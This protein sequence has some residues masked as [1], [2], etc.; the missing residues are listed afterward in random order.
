MSLTGGPTDDWGLPQHS[1][2]PPLE[3][4]PP[5]PQTQ[6]DHHVLSA[7]GVVQHAP[8]QIPDLSNLP[9]QIILD[10]LAAKSKAELGQ[11]ATD[12]NRLG[13]KLGKRLVPLWKNEKVPQGCMRCHSIHA[14]CDGKRPCGRCLSR[15]VEAQCAY[16]S[17]PDFVP[18]QRKQRTKPNKRPLEESMPEPVGEIVLEVVAKAHSQQ[19]Q[20][21]HL[22]MPPQQP[23]PM[24]QQREQ[25]P[26]PPQDRRQA[27]RAAKESERPLRRDGVTPSGDIL[28]PHGIEKRYCLDPGCVE[29]GAGKAMCQHGRRK[30]SCKEPDCKNETERKRQE[31]SSRRCIHGRQKRLCREG[32]CLKEYSAASKAYREQMQQRRAEGI[33]PSIKLPP[34]VKYIR[35]VCQQCD[36]TAT[37]GLKADGRKVACRMHKEEEHVDL[38]KAIC[39]VEGCTRPARFGEVGARPT[40]CVEHR[41]P[42][43]VDCA[44]KRCEHVDPPTDATSGGIIC[45]AGANYGDALERKRRFCRGSIHLPFLS[46]SFPL[47]LLR[48]PIP[49]FSLPGAHRPLVAKS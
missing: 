34:V 33:A 47:S 36:Q 40:T 45:V 48:V 10:A 14:R 28:C 3:Q 46:L 44:T 26:P 4:Q 37:F 20:P 19:L 12:L 23:E 43:Y 42:E 2:A 31:V 32:D 41:R 13:E 27:K 49:S 39:A 16:P 21:P 1:E 5:P 8:G 9:V 18:P 24:Q 29:N 22:P 35:R 7:V 6:Q 25:P 38:S 11:Y 15:N 17:D 30:R